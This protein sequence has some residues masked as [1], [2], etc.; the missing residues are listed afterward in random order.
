M[1]G[2]AHGGQ[3]PY[4]RSTLDQRRLG[5][6]TFEGQ[7]YVQFNCDAHGTSACGCYS[8][9]VAHV[10]PLGEWAYTN[11]AGVKIKVACEPAALP[12]LGGIAP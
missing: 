2:T 7:R 9:G 6:V 3:C 8:L 12:L 1:S 10:T 11:S 5:E 4:C